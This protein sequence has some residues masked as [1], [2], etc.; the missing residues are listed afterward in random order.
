LLG[1]FTK[2]HIGGDGQGGGAQHT[3]LTIVDNVIFF[4][5]AEQSNQKLKNQPS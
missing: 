3:T 5:L 2:I 1:L 4:S